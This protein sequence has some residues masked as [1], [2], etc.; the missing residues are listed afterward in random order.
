MRFLILAFL[1]LFA[2]ASFSQ[3]VIL[4]RNGEQIDCKI[5]RVDSAIIHYD[6]VKGERKLSSYVAK[7]EVRSYKINP[8]VD[9]PDVLAP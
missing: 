4:L 7:N 5:T 6:F 9:V 2:L 1:S 3:D 8:A